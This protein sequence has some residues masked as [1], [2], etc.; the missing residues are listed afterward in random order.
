MGEGDVGW[1]LCCWYPGEVSFVGVVEGC[2]LRFSV[3]LA[4]REVLF[5][6]WRCCEGLD[7]G[8]FVV[9]VPVRSMRFNLPLLS[10]VGGF[11][12]FGVVVGCFLGGGG[13]GFYRFG[14]IVGCFLGGGDGGFS[15]QHCGV[16]CR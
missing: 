11:C 5:S 15:R 4:W 1:R 13:G 14:V 3:F 10:K 12:C 16:R 7:G 8:G 2:S 9:G 6:G